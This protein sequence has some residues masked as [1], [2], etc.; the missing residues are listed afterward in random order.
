[1]TPAATA[2]PPLP[3]V[4][5]APPAHPREER[6]HALDN[7]RAVA[8]F[9][10]IVLH[11]ALSFMVTPIP[12]AARDAS[13]NL[14]FDLM[15]LFIHGFRMQLFFFIAGFF[16]RMLHERLGTTAFAKQRLKRIGVP[17]ILGWPLFVVP[18]LG[19][20]IWGMMQREVEIPM[21]EQ[22]R[23]LDAIP[24]AHLWFLQYLL[25]IYTFALGVQMLARRVSETTLAA[26]DRTFDRLMQ[27]PLR[28]LPFVPL[29]IA[30]LWN[31]RML[32][33]VEDAGM[34]L[35]PSFSGLAYYSLFFAVGWWLHRRRGLLDQLKRFAA[36]SVAIAVVA[37]LTHGIILGTQPQPSHPQYLVLKTVSLTCVSLYAWLM[38]FAVTGWFLRFAGQ[39][40][41]WLRYLADASYW[42][43][44]AHMVP[45]LW[46]Q[47]VL[48][49]WEFNGPLKF[50]LINAITM[51]LL[52]G[53]YHVFVRYTFIGRILNGPRQRPTKAALP[54][55]AAGTV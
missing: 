23:G 48:A 4:S 53:S 36:P 50:I 8:M 11:A 7:L 31:G 41:P 19:L 34:G 47:I 39:H 27:S 14:S 51:A 17:F 22:R 3:E 1:M 30:C 28:V 18:T 5:S 52:L 12:W 38:T 24:T 13:A 49:K 37:L 25:A 42:C 2:P 44:L 9:L 45:V 15:V 35:F 43:Y 33:E 46:L 20:L 54:A 29:T 16:G 55:T 10:G 6:L 40:Q 21:P 26:L 32:G